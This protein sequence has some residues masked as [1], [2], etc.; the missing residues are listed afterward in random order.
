LVY[1][2]RSRYPEFP[3]DT[4]AVHS[5]TFARVLIMA[6]QNECKEISHVLEG[7]GISGMDMTDEQRRRGIANMKFIGH[8]FLRK[9]LS[10]KI[11]SI[12]AINS[13]C[14]TDEHRI[15]CACQLMQVI[16]YTLDSTDSGRNLLTKL[17]ARLV[18]LR[19]ATGVD[20]KGLL[21]KRLFYK[22]QDLL[23]LQTR[24]WQE[25]LLREHARTIGEVHREAE[26]EARCV[27]RGV[28]PAPFATRTISGPAYITSTIADQDGGQ[29]AGE[30][31]AVTFEPCN[32]PQQTGISPSSDC[33]P[34]VA[35][36]HAPL[37]VSAKIPLDIEGVRRLLTGFVTERDPE[38]LVRDWCTPMRQLGVDQED[39]AAAQYLLKI[40]LASEEE[41]LQGAYAEAVAILVS[42]GAVTWTAIGAAMS[43]LFGSLAALHLEAPHSGLFLQQLFARLLICD[44]DKNFDPVV[45]KEMRPEED[46][47]VLKSLL[48]GVL[49]KVRA[50]GGPDMARRAFGRRELSAA[51]RLAGGFTRRELARTLRCEGIID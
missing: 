12:V 8:L 15:E 28:A 16:G 21:S 50:W 11:I 24:G 40:G 5:I 45:M 14:G 33:M 44:D 3:P 31:L 51:L 32:I 35:E 37:N 27:G 36:E 42:R 9:L 13:L 29:L 30:N 10:E 19:D 25:K 1:C 4:G 48:I 39:D 6:V 23:D 46:G 41:E 49:N 38:K 26:E 2:L 18:Q 47:E 7:N 17:S 43:P 20:G 34:D 22:I